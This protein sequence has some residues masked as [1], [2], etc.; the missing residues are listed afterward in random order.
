VERHLLQ[1]PAPSI[2]Q[3][4]TCISYLHSDGCLLSHRLVHANEGYIVVQIIDRALWRK[5]GRGRWM[6]NWALSPLLMSQLLSDG[7]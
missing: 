6:G 2:P 3:K 5:E 7:G 4:G 1:Q